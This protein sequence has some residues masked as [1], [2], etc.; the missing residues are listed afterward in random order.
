L[1]L[2]VGRRS[3]ASRIDVAAVSIKLIFAFVG[4]L[5][6]LILT[7]QSAVDHSLAGREFRASCI[8]RTF[9]SEM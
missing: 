2:E 4:G 8:R 3:E 5:A 9:P 7:I 1:P 6:A